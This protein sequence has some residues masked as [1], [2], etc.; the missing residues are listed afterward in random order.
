[1]QR[2]EIPCICSVFKAYTPEQTWKCI[3]DRL[4]GPCYPSRDDHGRKIRP[5]K[6]NTDIG[7]YSSVNRTIKLLNQLPA[8]VIATF[9]CKSHIF[10]KK[11]R[12]VIISK[13]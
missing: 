12:N 4:K 9:L 1:M 5:R 2:G 6:Q 13:K 11:V 10:R 3:G 7:K 8:E